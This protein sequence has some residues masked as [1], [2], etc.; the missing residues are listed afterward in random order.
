MKRKNLT[1]ALVAFA[2]AASC[3]STSTGLISTANDGGVEFALGDTSGDGIVDAKDASEILAEYTRL[4]TNSQG[5]FSGSRAKAA[6][7]NQNGKIDSSDASS[8]L[9]FYSYSSTG[10]DLNLVSF[11]DSLKP[12]GNGTTTTGTATT[13]T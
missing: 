8:V 7:V 13:T 6:D 11:L 5:F 10:G 1:A 4:S 2:M 12:A 9:M 3:I